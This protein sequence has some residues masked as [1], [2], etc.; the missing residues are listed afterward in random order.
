MLE[1]NSQ[2][3]SKLA[4]ALALPTFTQLAPSHTQPGGSQLLTPDT[5]VITELVAVV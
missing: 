4:I 1:T 3:S 5:L 2:T